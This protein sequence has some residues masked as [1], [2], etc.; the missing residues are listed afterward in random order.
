M[1][2]MGIITLIYLVVGV[3]VA[4]AKD[5]F[6]GVDDVF[7]LVNILLAIVL[8]PLVLLGVDFSLGGGEKGGDKGGDKKNGALLLGPSS[9]LY[10]RTL[11]QER[12]SKA[13]LERQRIP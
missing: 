11:I 1:R 3:L 2:G 7:D 5:Y 10:L 13:A 12:I 4:V 9:Y 8:W 6:G